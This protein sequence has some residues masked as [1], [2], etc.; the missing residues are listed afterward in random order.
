MTSLAFIRAY[1]VHGSITVI[2]APAPS[3]APGSA[4]SATRTGS[5][6][7]CAGSAEMGVRA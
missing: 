5:S 1:P 3:S 2:L 6:V 7:M 4:D